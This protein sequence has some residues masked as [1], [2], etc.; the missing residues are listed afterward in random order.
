MTTTKAR[1]PKGIRSG[2]QFTET[3][4]REAAVQLTDEEKRQ[5]EL[6]RPLTVQEVESLRRTHGTV[7]P[8]YG[9]YQRMPKV[10]EAAAEKAANTDEGRLYLRRI[11]QSEELAHI[12]GGPAREIRDFYNE[13]KDLEPMSEGWEYLVGT[14]A[15]IWNRPRG[16]V[17]F[18]ESKMRAATGRPSRDELVSQRAALTAQIDALDLNE[19]AAAIRRKYPIAAR[20][21]A[22]EG[23]YPDEI[24]LSFTDANGTVLWAGNSRDVPEL[25]PFKLIPENYHQEKSPLRTCVEPRDE[26]WIRSYNLNKM[27]AVTAEDLA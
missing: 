26:V 27:A 7:D 19:A 5:Q 24:T 18:I 9:Y 12:T 15:E 4:L 1:Q 22:T 10:F 14:W 13:I 23:D 17:T 8:H 20:I 6:A 16:E 11:A 21:V 25:K 2:G 3:R